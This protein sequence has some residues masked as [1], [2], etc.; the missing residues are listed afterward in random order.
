MKMSCQTWSQRN[1]FEMS[2]HCT[3]CGNSLKGDYPGVP[4]SRCGSVR[5]TFNQ[6]CEVTVPVLPSME[7]TKTTPSL[8]KNK[9]TRVRLLQ[10]WDVRRSV[11][12]MVKKFRRIDRDART[13]E[14][15]VE[16]EDGIVLHECRESLDEHTGHGSAKFKPDESRD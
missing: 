8:P 12:D 5:R 3:D 13:Y 1:D 16:T 2:W 14:E 6:L 15:R 4:C 11:G 9:R 10:G 7:A